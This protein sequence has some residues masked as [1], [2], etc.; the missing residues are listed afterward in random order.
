MKKFSNITGQQIGEKPQT[1]QK[2]DERKD[3]K[4]KMMKLMEKTLSIQTYGPVDR[5]L[6]AGSISIKGQELLAEALMQLLDEG[7]TKEQTKLLE[8]LKSEVKD[9]QA[10]DAKIEELNS[11]KTD[12]KVNNK[13]NVLLEKYDSETLLEVLKEKVKGINDI[14]LLEEYM[15]SFN[16]T[17]VVNISEINNIINERIKEIKNPS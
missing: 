17:N 11:N 16:Q 5:Y 9:W 6:R 7:S 8:S 15:K 10:I 13:V 4:V 3:L 14:S 2:V 1:D 12:Y